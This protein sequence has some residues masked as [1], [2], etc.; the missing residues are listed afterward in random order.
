MGR[1]AGQSSREDET[2]LGWRGEPQPADPAVS[3]A[4]LRSL[5]R[6]ADDPHAAAELLAE[7]SRRGELSPDALELAALCGDP[8]A[9]A[10]A[11]EAPAPVPDERGAGLVPWLEALAAH[12]PRAVRRALLG[13][14]WPA[15]RGLPSGAPRRA[16]ESGA[17]IALARV[18]LCPCRP[19][20]EWLLDPER[21][22]GL[23]N[24][25]RALDLRRALLGIQPTRALFE[26]A[27]ARLSWTR[28]LAAA[29]SDLRDWALGDGARGSDPLCAS[30][31]SPTSW[32]S[33]QDLVERL[34]GGRRRDLEAVLDPA[35]PYFGDP[36]TPEALADRALSFR[37]ASADPEDLGEWAAELWSDLGPQ[38][39][40]D[41]FSV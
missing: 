12:D 8:A 11:A 14:T 41:A 16:W 20:L 24:W 37:P 39:E 10:V 18:T 2:G 17:W 3:D 34:A 13:A 15:I 36:A 22:A 25:G 33:R 40:F 26:E 7:R 21:Q 1:A 38:A 9:L 31:K 4:R 27:A 29:C 23:G 6:D 30:W 28:I 5:A 32:L 19:H 35:F